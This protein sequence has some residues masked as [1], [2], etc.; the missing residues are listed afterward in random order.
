MMFMNSVGIR[1]RMTRLAM[2][3]SN[4]KC[5]IRSLVREKDPESTNTQMSGSN[6]TLPWAP[7]GCLTPRPTGRLT[8]GRK[9][10]LALIYGTVGQQLEGLEPCV[11]WLPARKQMTVHR[12]TPLPSRAVKVLT[13]NIVCV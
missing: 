10:T 5:Q 11:R 1:P 2:A 13:E 3:R 12:W 9:A 4:C 8:V 6:K 7:G